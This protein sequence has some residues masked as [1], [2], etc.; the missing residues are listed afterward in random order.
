MHSQ[1]F[2]LHRELLIICQDTAALIAA[3]E[4]YVTLDLLCQIHNTVG[5][6]AVWP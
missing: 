4:T 3:R 2:S 6:H 5:L 1:S